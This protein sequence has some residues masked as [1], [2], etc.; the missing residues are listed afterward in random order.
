MTEAHLPGT[1]EEC[2]QLL[3]AIGHVQSLV[4]SSR[5]PQFVLNETLSALLAVTG[6]EHGFLGEVRTGD[7]GQRYIGLSSVQTRSSDPQ[8]LNFF[9]QYDQREIGFYKSNSLIGQVLHYQEPLV[10]N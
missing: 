10:T 2:H 9:E 1:L 7:Q 8:V 4:T 5:D 3:D 6:S